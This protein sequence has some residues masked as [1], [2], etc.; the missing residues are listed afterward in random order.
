VAAYGASAK[1]VTLLSYCGVGAERLE[2]V[3]DRSTYKQG[4]RYP[5]GALPILPPEALLARRP[6]YALLLTWNFADEIL[7]QQ[8]DY[9]AAGGRFII[10]L[11]TPRVV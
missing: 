1:G 3:V 6:D 5:A 7:A 9:R 11:P 10:P 4:Q 2:F 8:A